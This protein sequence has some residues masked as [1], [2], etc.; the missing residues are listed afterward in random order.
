MSTTSDPPFPPPSSAEQKPEI[1]KENTPT[2]GANYTGDGKIKQRKSAPKALWECNICL[3]TAKEPVITQC[4][5][6][7]C[8]PCIHKWLIMH[9]MHQ[10]CPVCNKDIVEEL[11]IPLYGNESDSQPSR[12]GNGSGGSGGVGGDGVVVG[13]GSKMVVEMVIVAVMVK[14]RTYQRFHLDHK[15]CTYLQIQTLRIISLKRIQLMAVT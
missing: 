12:K 15:E 8:W 3:E 7:Y 13:G 9:P 4:G 1:Q 10:S 11:L 6:L 5:H 2:P 14:K